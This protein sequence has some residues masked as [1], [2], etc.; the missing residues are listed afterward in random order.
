MDNL[1]YTS[2]N[3]IIFLIIITYILNIC[4]FINIIVFKL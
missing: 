3:K 2:F 4:T 1:F